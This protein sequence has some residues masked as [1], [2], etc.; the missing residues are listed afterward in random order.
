MEI[1][2]KPGHTAA[3]AFTAA[4][5]ASQLM[6]MKALNGVG[7]GQRKNFYTKRYEVKMCW[8]HLIF[9]LFKSLLGSQAPDCEYYILER[10]RISG[11]KSQKHSF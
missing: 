2:I 1:L 3:L 8:Q 9:P 10:R 5:A 7:Y 6:A 11:L 4:L